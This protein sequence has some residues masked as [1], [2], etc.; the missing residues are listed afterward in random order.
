MA[1]QRTAEDV[2]HQFMSQIRSAAYEWSAFPDKTTAQ[3]LDGLVHSIL[4]MID[5]CSI[6]TPAFDLVARPHP[7]DKQHC[8]DEG[9]DWIE[10]GTV[11][12]AD[13]ALHELLN[14]YRIA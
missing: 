8:I 4:A 2:R 13:V 11:I 10:D 12:N 5:G 9:D 3:R 6:G 1:T 7:D 14:D